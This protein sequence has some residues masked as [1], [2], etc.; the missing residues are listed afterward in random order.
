MVTPANSRQTVFFG[1]YELNCHTGELRRNGTALKLQPQPARVL[2]ILATRAG[3]IVTRQELTDEVWGAET[4]V[5]FE[6]GLNYA[7]QQIRSVLEDDPKQPRFL[8]TIPRRGVHCQCRTV[9]QQRV[10]G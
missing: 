3:E 9:G 6:H 1:E 7:I 8:E 5:D 2:A 10:H 4:H